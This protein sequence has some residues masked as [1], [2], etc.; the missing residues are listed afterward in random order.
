VTTTRR[1]SYSRPMD[2]LR[3]FYVLEGLD[4]AGTTTQL[5]MAGESVPGLWTTF[6]PTDSPVG[7]LLRRILHQEVDAVPGTIARLFAADRFEHLEGAEGIRERLSRGE[8]VLCDRYLFSSLAYQGTEFNFDAVW[9]LNKDFPLPEVLF[10]VDV[11]VH[12]TQRRLVDRSL[13]E[14]YDGRSFQDQLRAG[15]ERAFQACSGHGMEI[16]RLDGTLSAEQISS[17]IIEIVG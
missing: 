13:E 14:R 15:Y 11:P 9:A 10:F 8:K 7:T 16:V 17:S 4:G 6:E 3:G 5:R 2:V 12:E 1:A